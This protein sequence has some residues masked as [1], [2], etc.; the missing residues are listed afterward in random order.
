MAEP[1]LA[2]D[3]VRYVGEPVAM[4]LTDDSYQ[5]ED[6]AEL[7]S[8]DYEPLPAVIGV[9]GALADRDAAVPRRRLERGRW[10][11][12]RPPTTRRSTAATWWSGGRS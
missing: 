6:A 4:V 9:D 11:G 12:R 2:V 10:I 1:L 5:G 8:V 3:R 7:V